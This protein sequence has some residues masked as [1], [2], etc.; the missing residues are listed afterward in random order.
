MFWALQ[1][2]TGTFQVISSQQNQGG[3]PV[4]QHHVKLPNYWVDIKSSNTLFHGHEWSPVNTERL[5]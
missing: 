5:A 2:T 1:F 3:S 4:L